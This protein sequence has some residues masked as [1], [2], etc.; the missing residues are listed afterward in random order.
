VRFTFYWTDERR[1][2]GVDF[3]VELREA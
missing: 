1:W 3:A 2:E